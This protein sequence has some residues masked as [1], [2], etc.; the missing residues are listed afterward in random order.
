M[1]LLS[2]GI[3]RLLSRGCYREVVIVIEV[4]IARLLSRG[5]YRE[6]VIVRL[7][8]RGLLS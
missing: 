6:V 3:A 5:C 4:V 7:L 8:S 2:R 1:R